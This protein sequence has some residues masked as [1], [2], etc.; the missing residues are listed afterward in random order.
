MVAIGLL[1]LFFEDSILVKSHVAKAMPT[2]GSHGK[3]NY[4]IARSLI[5]IQVQRDPVSYNI[6]HLTVLILTPPRLA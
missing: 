4:R 2:D 3:R 1:Y 5:G 6:L